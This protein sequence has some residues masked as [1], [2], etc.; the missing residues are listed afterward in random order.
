M[1]HLSARIRDAKEF[2]HEAERSLPTLSS[3]DQSADVERK[4]TTANTRWTPETAAELYITAGAGHATCCEFVF[5]AWTRPCSNRTLCLQM[6]TAT[7]TA[8]CSQDIRRGPTCRFPVSVLSTCRAFYDTAGE[9][10]E[11]S[12]AP[13][14]HRSVHLMVRNRRYI[15]PPTFSPSTTSDGCAD[16][17]FA[18]WYNK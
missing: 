11:G 14:S 17:P 8:E 6:T 5:N 15:E 16:L 2:P 12:A 3:P 18:G 13:A 10:A 7:S 9:Q 4:R 1:L